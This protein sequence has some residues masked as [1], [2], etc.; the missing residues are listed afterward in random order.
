MSCEVSLAA[1]IK[2]L[3]LCP[4]TWAAYL[5]TFS[6]DIM[7]TRVFCC[8]DCV[9]ITWFIHVLMLFISFVVAV[10]VSQVKAS[11]RKGSKFLLWCMCG[12]DCPPKEGLVCNSFIADI[13]VVLLEL[14]MSSMFERSTCNIDSS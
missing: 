8:D 5:L 1:S 2:M 12:C 6:I 9:A 3:I 14:Y 13:I 11:P 10:P 4:L 7:C